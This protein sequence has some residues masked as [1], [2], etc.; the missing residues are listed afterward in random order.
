[1]RRPQRDDVFVVPARPPR[2][3]SIDFLKDDAE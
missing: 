2:L 3:F 1:M